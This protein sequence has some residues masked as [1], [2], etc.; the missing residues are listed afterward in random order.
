MPF[1]QGCKRL[2]GKKRPK[3]GRLHQSK[4]R[5]RRFL[6]GYKRQKSHCRA[7]GVSAFERAENFKQDGIHNSFQAKMS[8][9]PYFFLTVDIQTIMVAALRVLGHTCTIS[10]TYL[11]C[12]TGDVCGF[13]LSTGRVRETTVYTHTLSFIIDKLTKHK[14]SN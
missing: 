3:I 9:M 8:L 12:P 10:R 6:L 4:L 11:S 13:D 5:K 1:L 7:M 14:L 2:Q